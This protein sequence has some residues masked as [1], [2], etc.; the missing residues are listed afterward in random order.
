MGFWSYLSYQGPVPGKAPKTDAVK[1]SSNAPRQ[2]LPG[3]MSWS[4]LKPETPGTAAKFPALEGPL[5]V[6]VFSMVAQW[7]TTWALKSTV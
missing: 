7:V 6:L 5:K 4:L 2:G 1:V 3:K